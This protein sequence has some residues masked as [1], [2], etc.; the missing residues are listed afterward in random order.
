MEDEI[1]SPSVDDQST[2]QTAPTAASEPDRTP[3]AAPPSITE[4]PK[5]GQENPGL[6]L[7]PTQKDLSSEAFQDGSMGKEIEPSWWSD[8]ANRAITAGEGS[9]FSQATEWLDQR[10][11]QTKDDILGVAKIS[12]ED[13]NKQFPGMPEPFTKPVDPAVARI[14]YDRYQS[15]RLRQQWA[16]HGGEHPWEDFGLGVAVGA[17]DPLNIALG[18]ATEGASELAGLGALAEGSFARQVALSAAKNTVLGG[19]LAAASYEFEKSQHTAPDMAS[20]LEWGA[21]QIV[22]MTALHAGWIK[23]FGESEALQKA[24]PKDLQ[25]EAG[26]T[27]IGQE[28]SGAKVDTTPQALEARSRAAG[29]MEGQNSPYR[30]Q[31]LQH[32]SDKPFY[33]AVDNDGNHVQLAHTEHGFHAVDDPMAANHMAGEGGKVGQVDIP[34]ES[35]FID[36]KEPL[37]EDVLKIAE[38]AIKNTG[39][40]FSPEELEHLKELPAEEVLKA[41]SQT[42]EAGNIPPELGNALKEAGYAGIRYT[43]TDELN[44][45]VHNGVVLF[46]PPK[47]SRIWQADPELAKSV[48]DA[49]KEAFLERS[50]GPDA[51]KTATPEIEREL[52]D[53]KHEAPLNSKPDYLDPILEENLKREM[54]KLEARAE[55]DPDTK[56]ELDS[57]KEDAARDSQEKRAAKDLGDCVV[58]STL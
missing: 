26:R 38:D 28:E 27:A 13:A 47:P 2:V 4:G 54:A 1:G 17:V 15:M 42:G 23:V 57:L 41:L 44:R 48:P 10:I 52:H 53:F 51:S 35:K 3:A 7:P 49:Q 6:N 29:E 56:A 25:G 5:T 45:P 33:A 24:T 30:F 50:M 18:V 58:G 55:T 11:A 21:A 32:P 9:T 46:D 22:G 19:G 14:Q 39:E 34:K 12:P 8:L 31:N 37:P 36:A 16:M 43:A 40:E 20:T